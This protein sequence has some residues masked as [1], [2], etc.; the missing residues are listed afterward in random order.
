MSCRQRLTQYSWRQVM[1]DGCPGG[2]DPFRAV[3]G[4]FSG[5]ALSPSVYALAIDG[6]E[7]NAAAVKTAKAGL[8]KIDKRHLNFA[9]C[10]RFNLHRCFKKNNSS[11][12]SNGP[13]GIYHS[14]ANRAH[15]PR[16]PDH[17]QTPAKSLFG[18]APEPRGRVPES[19]PMLSTRKF[20]LV[21]RLS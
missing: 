11:F 6:Q 13:A 20:G 7:E 16:L 21:Q 2:L 14:P 12:R 15:S 4:I 8:E 1:L 5:D 9:Q 17:R 10:D 18:C 19:Q 3:E